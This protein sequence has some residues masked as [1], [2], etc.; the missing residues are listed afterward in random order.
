VTLQFGTDG[1]RGRA[2]V[3]LTPELALA[4]GRASARVLGSDCRWL[5]GRD[6]RRSGPMVEAALAAGLQS[7]G[8][9]VALLGVVPTPAVAWACAREG[10]PG[11]VISASHNPFGDN[12]IKLFAAGGRKLA[13]DLEARIEQELHRLDGGDGGRPQG[14]AVGVSAGVHGRAEEYG[15]WLVSSVGEGHLAGLH[16]VLDCGH[17]AASEL[18]GEVFAA[19]GARV[20]VI[21]AAPDG[22]NINEASGATHTE[23]LQAAVVAEGADAGLAF[24]GDADRCVAVDG[25]GHVVD[26]DR[27]IAV[28]AIDR[29]GRGALTGGAVA[30]TV[31]ANLG[32][33]LAMQAHGIG[34]V[35]TAVGDRYVL[36]ALEERGL[37]L[38]GE[39]S[40]HVIFRDVATTGDGMLTGLQLLDVVVRSGRSLAD[41]SAGA[42][43]RFPQ[44]LRNVRVPARIP[45]LDVLIAA[46]LAAA[47]ARLGEQGRVLIRPSGTEPVIRVMV[48]AHDAA[49]ADAVCAELVAA[50]QRAAG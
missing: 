17:G 48:E 33:R 18:A 32:F 14:S 10:A 12:G 42:M 15:R 34:I 29:H 45:D 4:L 39:Q 11:A 40:G 5:I 24:D 23:A 31:M 37:V 38:G 28:C 43:E 25:A 2:N 47:Q 46:D 35:E 8:A 21:N 49:E 30:V 50:V 13:D 22:C 36:D 6:T 1:V 44:V 20:T 16:V 27:M 3:E 19:A 26:G 9:D 41:L 7:E